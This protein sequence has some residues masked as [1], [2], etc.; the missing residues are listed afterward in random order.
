M[1]IPSW[2]FGS[3]NYHNHVETTQEQPCLLM[4][5]LSGA[6]TYCGYM[7]GPPVN[8]IACVT[9][10]VSSLFWSRPDFTSW[11]WTLEWFWSKIS[12]AMLSLALL[13]NGFHLIIIPW[14]VGNCFLWRLKGGPWSL[15][16][17]T[18]HHAM[19]L[20]VLSTI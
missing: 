14:C 9:G 16:F 17:Y 8:T 11:R 5:F 10:V 3:W 18:F 7:C 1:N 19:V 4:V 2:P 20:L 15:T 6:V 12:Y 13:L